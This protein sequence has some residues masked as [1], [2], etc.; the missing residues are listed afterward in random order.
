MGWGRCGMC[1]LRAGSRPCSEAG[2]PRRGS[3]LRELREAAGPRGQRELARRAGTRDRRGARVRDGISGFKIRSR[4]LNVVARFAGGQGPREG[5][6][7][8]PTREPNRSKALRSRGRCIAEPRSER[9]GL[10]GHLSSGVDFFWRP[11]GKDFTDP[12]PWPKE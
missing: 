12:G 1:R 5:R 10:V 4:E 11:Q 8:D 9:T 6:V 3:K 2:S 7:P